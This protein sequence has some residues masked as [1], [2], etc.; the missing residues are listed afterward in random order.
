ML[1]TRQL[2][3]TDFYK[4]ELKIIRK[5]CFF[6]TKNIFEAPKMK[7]DT[8]LFLCTWFV[9][10]TLYYI[11]LRIKVV[12]ESCKK[13]HQ[14]KLFS[15]FPSQWHSYCCIP[16]LMRL[17]FLFL[18][19]P[20]HSNHQITFSFGFSVC[21]NKISPIKRCLLANHCVLSYQ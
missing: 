7:Y 9:V 11:S 8:K 16:Y 18:L 3:R 2:M 1:R 5:I 17:T 14:K 6:A 15:L 4:F 20:F 10:Q 19:K 12:R 21:S 13:I